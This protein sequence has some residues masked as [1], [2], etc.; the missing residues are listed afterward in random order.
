MLDRYIIGNHNRQSPEADIPIIDVNKIENKLGGAANVAYNLKSIG[1]IPILISIIGSDQNGEYL[2]KQSNKASIESHFIIDKERQTTVKT[3]IVDESFRQYIRYDE[4]NQNY[5]DK[6]TYLKVADKLAETV[7]N[8]E[9]DA[10]II[11]D[12]NKGLLNESLIKLIQNLCASEGIKLLVDPKFKNFKLLS[13][14]DIFKPNFSEICS[15]L[16]VKNL[17][18]ESK[19][20]IA[21]LSYAELNTEKIFVTLAEF[22]VFYKEGTEYGHI[23]GLNIENPDVSGAGDTVIAVLSVLTLMDLDIRTIAQTINACGALVCQRE[24]ISV[25]RQA[26]FI[27]ILA[28]YA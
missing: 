27:D 11:Q 13:K 28:K 21:A 6:V 18:K 5:I 17:K 14:C 7:K 4:E 22:G 10:L 2:I 9:I 19:S 3:R 26:E 23:K 15:Y 1:C 24:G 12:Y 25:I 20:L 8:Q 16:G